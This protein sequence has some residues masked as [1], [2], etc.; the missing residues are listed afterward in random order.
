[1]GTMLIGFVSRVSFGHSGRP[2]QAP[3]WLW[4]V[5]WSAHFAAA[6]RVLASLLQLTVL[7]GIADHL[8]YRH[9]GLGSEIVAR[10]SATESRWQPA[11]D[12]VAES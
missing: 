3:D 11:D 1:M 7:I 4:L 9:I 6:L 8:D 12:L 2:L 10:I 5:Y